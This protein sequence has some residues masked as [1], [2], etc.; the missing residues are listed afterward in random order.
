MA[1]CFRVS[2]SAESSM[3]MANMRIQLEQILTEIMNFRQR[4]RYSPLNLQKP[5]IKA[6]STSLCHYNR[7]IGLCFRRIMV[8]KNILDGSFKYIAIKT[9]RQNLG[10]IKFK[11]G[12]L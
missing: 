11:Q 2:I 10:Q 8:F 7:L 5:N 3:V 6:P 1:W 12:G 9:L 4:R